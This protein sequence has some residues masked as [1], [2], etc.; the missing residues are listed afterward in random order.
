MKILVIA[1]VIIV[2]AIVEAAVDKALG[3]DF[4]NVSRPKR[5]THGVVYGLYG[6][7]IGT[8]IW[9]L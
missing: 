4:P 9:F 6:V 7:A 5:I 8:C 1:L 3:I 2:G